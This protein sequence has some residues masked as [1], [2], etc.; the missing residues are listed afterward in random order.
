MFLVSTHSEIQVSAQP[1]NYE[2]NRDNYD[3]TR[4][5]ETEMKAKIDRQMKDYNY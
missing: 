1:V 5:L 3:L 2:P 4:L